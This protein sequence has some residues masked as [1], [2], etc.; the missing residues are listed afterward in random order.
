MII[1]IDHSEIVHDWL[2]E[3]KRVEAA[4]HAKKATEYA[5]SWIRDLVK[6][7]GDELEKIGDR[8]EKKG[9]P[10]RDNLDDRNRGLYTKKKLAARDYHGA[11]L[12]RQLIDGDTL[13]PDELATFSWIMAIDLEYPEN[14]RKTRRTPEEIRRQS[15][16]IFEKDM[17]GAR[18]VLF[19]HATRLLKNLKLQP[20]KIS[21]RGF[22]AA[23][24]KKVAEY[25]EISE[26]VLKRELAH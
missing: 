4:R 23:T 2:T 10:K 7:L 14:D 9:R 21:R 12:A 6:I 17:R 20:A 26:D 1:K 24:R 18:D 13:D 8:H 22:K 3:G 16:A 5:E 15:A 19:P 25:W 11:V